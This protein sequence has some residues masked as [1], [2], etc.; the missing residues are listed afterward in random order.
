MTPTPEQAERL[1]LLMEDC[2]EV[3][4]I[5]SK[6][7]RH[8]WGESRD[9]NTGRVYDNTQE[10][11]QELGDLEASRDLLYM[12]QDVSS[13]E[14]A[15]ARIAKLRKVLKYLH[16]AQNQELVTEILTVECGG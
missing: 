6:I 4:Q 14:V 10:L 9:P 8:G 2:A 1:H 16:R 7:L 3:I 11:I 12:A 5:C 13:P 15:E